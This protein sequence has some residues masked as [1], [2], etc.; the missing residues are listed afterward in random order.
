MKKSRN[1]Y[2]SFSRTRRSRTR[3]SRTRRSRTRGSRTRRSRTRGSRTR[4]SRTRR[5]RTR[6]SRTRRGGDDTAREEK[7]K[8]CS[9]I[10]DKPKVVTENCNKYYF[11]D[12][13]VAYM[14]RNPNFLRKLGA[15]RKCSKTSAIWNTMKRCPGN[16]IGWKATG[17]ADWEE[18]CW[19][20]EN[21]EKKVKDASGNFV[22]DASG[23]FVKE[24]V[25]EYENVLNNQVFNIIPRGEQVGQV[26]ED[27]SWIDTDPATWDK[28]KTITA[29]R[30][31]FWNEENTMEKCMKKRDVNVN[32]RRKDIHFPSSGPLYDYKRPT[33]TLDKAAERAI[34]L[35]QK[36]G[37][38]KT[39]Q[40][41]N[42]STGVLLMSEKEK[43]DLQKKKNSNGIVGKGKVRFDI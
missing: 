29:G 31:G 10:Y 36:E 12:D 33:K 35:S 3:R 28:E 40:L 38:F 14:M 21:K 8:V 19:Y 9:E 17:A 13:G 27:L 5:S 26:E 16:S 37:T 1:K 20:K 34:T 23:N 4:R 32:V 22:K 7:G 30:R 2:H 18:P 11:L 15:K 39:E 24:Y 25:K 6:R 43:E 42:T 41:I